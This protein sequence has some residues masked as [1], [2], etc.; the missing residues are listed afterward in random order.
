[1]SSR[2]SNQRENMSDLLTILEADH[3]ALLSLLSD[4]RNDSTAS[5]ENRSKLRDAKQ[6]LATHL[7]KEQDQLYPGLGD[8]RTSTKLLNVFTDELAWLNRVA[9]G[10][11]QKYP[12]SG[13]GTE[14]EKD[15]DALT[16]VLKI[17]IDREEEQVYPV[18]LRNNA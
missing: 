2:R 1:M 15:I 4:V 17:H 13:S 3:R 12:D 18:Y 5:D 16:K 6:L 10:F 7:Q 9:N 11:F 8:S 14:F